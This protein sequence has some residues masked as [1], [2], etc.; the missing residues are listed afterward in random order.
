MKTDLSALPL[1]N[2]SPELAFSW[3]PMI[4][5]KGDMEII[6]YTV[7][8]MVHQ[9]ERDVPGTKRW[10]QEERPNFKD[11]VGLKGSGSP[12]G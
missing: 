12:R 9:A 6:K 2:L 1:N 5:G 4:L 11:S 7:A 10:K 3:G 8:A